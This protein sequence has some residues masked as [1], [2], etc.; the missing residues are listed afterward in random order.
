MEDGGGLR[1]DVGKPR[2]QAEERFCQGN[3]LPTFS[4]GGSIPRAA[5]EKGLQRELQSR[6]P[7][8]DSEGGSRWGCW[9]R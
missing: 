2:G 1:R 7:G 4:K 3:C 9:E 6:V 5:V 8:E